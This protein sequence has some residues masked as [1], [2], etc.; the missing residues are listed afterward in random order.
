[1]PSLQVREV[2]EHIYTKLHAEAK[3]EHRSFAQQAVATLAKGLDLTEDPKERRA[4]LIRKI[5][6]E[7][8]VTDT[9]RLDDP[10]VLIRKDRDR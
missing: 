10:V 9:S 2:P 6:E 1:M 7:P 8:F 4:K 3:K 5:M